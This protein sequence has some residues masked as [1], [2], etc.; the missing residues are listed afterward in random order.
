MSLVLNNADR[1]PIVG[2][3]I[4]HATTWYHRKS[5]SSEVICETPPPPYEKEPVH[6][7]LTQISDYVW[8][9]AS[10]SSTQSTPP[11]ITTEEVITRRLIDNKQVDEGISLLQMATQMNQ[12]ITG[13]HNQMSIDLYMMGLD[14]ILG[15]IPS[16]LYSYTH[17]H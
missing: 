13:K 7:R 10:F 5:N 2:S 3:P 6:S 14:K 1:L 16:K 17:I 12:D 15:S 8:K 11:V 4:G 9:R